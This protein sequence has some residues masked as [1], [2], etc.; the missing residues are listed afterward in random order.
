V[1]HLPTA[2]FEKTEINESHYESSLP[3]HEAAA[4]HRLGQKL[5]LEG[6]SRLFR[7]PSHFRDPGHPLRQRRKL[8]S[9]LLSALPDSHDL[10][11]PAFQTRS[12]SRK[13]LKMPGK[14]IPSCPVLGPLLPTLL[15]IPRNLRRLP[16]TKTK[17]RTRM[18]Q[19][20]MQ[21]RP[22]RTR[23]RQGK[24]KSQEE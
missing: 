3:R 19:R 16:R 23:R 8:V 6:R 10:P 20:G 18:S 22:L 9:L 11:I 2:P 1:R 5:G 17:T 21:L 13:H 7:G 24:S 4:E 15:L 14:T 12:S